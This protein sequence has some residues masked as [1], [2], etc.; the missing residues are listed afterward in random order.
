MTDTGQVRLQIEAGV[1]SV[2]FDRTQARNAMTWAMYEQLAAINRQLAA[3]RSV[4]V[5]VFRGAGGQAFVAGTDIEQFANFLSGDDGVAYE[6]QI[7]A[8]IELLCQL[9]M[10][11]VAVVEGWCVGGGLAI[12][13]ACDF[14]LATPG[15][16]FGV[17]I[18]KTL[19]NCLA[20]TNVARLRAAFGHQ[21]VKR[22]LMLAE[23]IAADEALA[24]G[25]LQAVETPESI[26]S[27]LATL[28]DRLSALAPVTQRVSKAALDRLATHELAPSEDLIRAA[29]DSADF[30]EGVAAFVAKRPPQWSGQ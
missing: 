29:Y 1:A 17:P 25:F 16:K 6:R 10:P 12:A 3:D 21:R 15:A 23:F 20:I 28:V 7:E 2:L 19:G 27:A 8:G 9:P 13:T 24:C 30:R 14:R 5:A 18:A 4:R 26:E 22:M 11:T